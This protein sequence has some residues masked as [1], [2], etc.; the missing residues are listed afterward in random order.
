MSRYHLILLALI[1]MV[2][3]SCSTSIPKTP[4][5]ETV[6]SINY[7]SAG[8]D[9]RILLTESPSVAFD[10]TSLASVLVEVRSG[11]EVLDSKTE[12]K[13][14]TEFGDSFD[15]SPVHR[16]VPK[17]SYTFGKYITANPE[18]GLRKASEKA[19]ELGADAI[20][21]LKIDPIIETTVSG[22]QVINTHAGYTISGMAVKR[23]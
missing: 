10:Y 2:A 22:S 11:Y 16:A 6:Y 4:Y 17:T 13:T 18:A 23:K 15:S 9:G 5:T 3:S 21:G 19:L 7:Y 20:I 1:A 12:Y 14:V 8:L